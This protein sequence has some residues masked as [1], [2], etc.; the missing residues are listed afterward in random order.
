MISEYP[1]TRISDGSKPAIHS[2]YD[3]CPEQPGGEHVLLSV[4]DQNSI[5]GLARVAI[6]TVRGDSLEHLGESAHCIGHT[7][8]YP[9]WIDHEHIAYH[10]GTKSSTTGW[11]K[12][13]LPTGYELEHPGSLRQFDVRNRRGLVLMKGSADNPHGFNQEV[14]II[15]HQGQ[16]G[17]RL[18]IA[19]ARSAHPDPDSLPAC[20]ELNF[21]NAKWSYDGSC[22]FVVFTNELFLKKQGSSGSKFKCLIV[23]DADGSHVRFLQDFTHHPHWSPDN[24]FAFAVNAVERRGHL[25]QDICAFDR[26]TGTKRTLL[27]DVAGIHSTILPDGKHLIIDE[28]NSP[29]AGQAQIVRWNLDTATK[30][31][32]VR[33]NHR[34]YAHSNGH[35]PHP[36]LSRDGKRIYFN[37]QDEGFCQVYSLDLV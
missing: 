19:E 11:V 6:G 23:A 37:A 4:W 2:Y 32:L 7:G 36:V 13:H 35:H 33:F 30:E 16:E 31:V 29:S 5:P 17:N 14:S 8:R 24:T 28:F 18:N 20:E 15:D 12:L 34:D 27:E 3:I 26:I 1:V 10:R 9:M 25:S 22:F 21:M